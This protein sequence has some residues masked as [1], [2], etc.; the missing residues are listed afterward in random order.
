MAC[1]RLFR[2][3]GVFGSEIAQRIG[4][5]LLA[6]AMGAFLYGMTAA[7]AISAD[8]QNKI[9]PYSG[10]ALPRFAALKADRVYLR[11]GPGR[12]YAIA[13][14]LRRR[15]MPVLI[16][17]EHGHWRK[18]RL[19]DGERGWI[20]RAML[21]PRS[22]AAAREQGVNIYEQPSRESKAIA[23]AERMAILRVRT[24]GQFWCEVDA[25]NLRGWV[26]R[27][28][29]WGVDPHQDAVSSVAVAN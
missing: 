2:I 21:T 3:Y 17:G 22:Y 25:L 20:H 9:G 27:E 14:E 23:R 8:S 11:R 26:R 12:N 13:W 7:P 4:K 24:C 16:L 29:L 1:E 15:R 19:Q 18:V 6:V 28:V 10:E 5:L